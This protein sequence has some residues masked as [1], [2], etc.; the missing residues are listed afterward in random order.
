MK[1]IIKYIKRALFSPEGYTNNPVYTETGN[2]DTQDPNEN[3]TYDW[4]N[5]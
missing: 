5:K 3:I 2:K 1:Q 4:A